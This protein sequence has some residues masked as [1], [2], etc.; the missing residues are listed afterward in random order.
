MSDLL[1]TLGAAARDTTWSS[2]FVASV[3]AYYT[4]LW[5]IS[6]RTRD[7][8]PVNDFHPT[9]VLLVPARNEELVI[10]GTVS[11]L[12][13]LDY[14]DY[15]V[16]VLDDGSADR[17]AEIVSEIAAADPRVLLVRRGPEIGGRGKSDVLNHGFRLVKQMVE[18][19]DPRFKGHAQEAVLIG[20][21]D[22]DGSLDRATLRTVAPY[23][24]DSRT[25]QLQIGVK[26]YNADVNVLTRMQDIEFVGFTSLVQVARDRIGSSGLGGNGQFT[27]LAALVDLGDLPWNP[28]SLTEDLDLGIRLVLRGWVT[29]FT[30]TVCVHQQGLTKW[31][32]LLRQRTRWIQGHY[33]CWRYLP[34][35][36]MSRKA[37]LIARLDLMNYLVLAVTV[38]VVSFN[39]VFGLVGAAGG[40]GL[41]NEFLTFVPAGLGRRCVEGLF[42]FTP[43]VA[44][45]Y[46]YQRHSDHPLRWWEVPAFGLIFT[47]YSYVWLLVSIRAWTRMLIGR[48]GWAKTPRVEAAV[49]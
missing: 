6:L 44:F 34:A 2:W 19:Q 17:T 43:I 8:D 24:A 29:R 4:A 26:I 46:T 32:P 13:D 37:R 38:V 41:H 11:A 22:A 5:M 40:L 48:S 20:I 45:T 27:R 49:S 47:A 9:V 18:S 36:A 21:V 7:R 12:L 23:F 25:G 16:M 15:L 14:D 3:V 28:K 1:H 33:N 30:S 42:V 31:R 39:L 35:L 10:G